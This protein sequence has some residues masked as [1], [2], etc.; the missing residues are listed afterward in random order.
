MIVTVLQSGGCRAQ[1]HTPHKRP[2]M[3]RTIL[4]AFVMRSL[5]ARVGAYA[6]RPY[7][8]PA[9]KSSPDGLKRYGGDL[10]R[11][12]DRLLHTF[13]NL[14]SG[15]CSVLQ[16]LTVPSRDGFFFE[17]KGRTSFFEL[18]F[19]MPKLRTPFFNRTFFGRKPITP[20]F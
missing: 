6:I 7:S 17:L 12:K 13:A 20:I 9:G 8:L 16:R 19:F 11:A 5:R 15:Q 10:F 18:S 3:G 14:F 2:S 4:R 1:K